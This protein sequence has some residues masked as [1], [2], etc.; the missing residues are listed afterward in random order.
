MGCAV[1]PIAYASI[2][3]HRGC[4]AMA[5]SSAVQAILLPGFEHVGVPTASV[6]AANTAQ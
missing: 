4:R 6:L 1:Q 3:K 5:R 2:P